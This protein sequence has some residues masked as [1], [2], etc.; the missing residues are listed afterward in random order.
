[1]CACWSP[2]FTVRDLRGKMY[3]NYEYLDEEFLEESVLKSPPRKTQMPLKTSKIS[4]SSDRY[5]LNF[6]GILNSVSSVIESDVE[7]DDHAHQN[8]DN[9]T[10]WDNI[11]SPGT[12]CSIANSSRPIKASS[13]FGPDTK[14]DDDTHQNANIAKKSDNIISHGKLCSI[15]SSNVSSQGKFWQVKIC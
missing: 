10:K 15:D 4:T 2:F 9:T 1:M 12:S 5:R 3:S 7:S 6:G 8:V 13:F 14:E 11:I